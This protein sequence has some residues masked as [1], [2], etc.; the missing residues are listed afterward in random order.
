MIIIEMNA[1]N[2][3]IGVLGK[4]DYI[5]NPSTCAYECDKTYGIVEYF[6]TKNCVCLERPFDKIILSCDRY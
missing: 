3:L 2:W 4:D 5:W 6:D 1:N